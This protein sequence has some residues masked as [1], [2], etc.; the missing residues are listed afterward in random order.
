[1]HVLYPICQWAIQRENLRSLKAAPKRAHIDTMTHFFFFFCV[2]AESKLG[3]MNTW[4]NEHLC[5]VLYMAGTCEAK[6]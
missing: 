2:R 1:M 4:A 3:H 5:S 6:L